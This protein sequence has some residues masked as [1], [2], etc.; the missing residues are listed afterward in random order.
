MKAMAIERYGKKVPLKEME[1]PVPKLGADEVLVEIYAA[2]INPVDYKL[3]DGAL[4]VLRSYKMP[5]I[6]GGDFAGVVKQVGINVT[7]FNVGD[8]VYG[9]VENDNYGTFAEYAVIGEDNA[10]L[11]PDSLSF[12]EAAAIP[13]AGLTAYQALTEKMHVQPGDHVLIHAGAGGVGSY[14]VQLGKALGVHV[15]TTVSSKGEALAKEL[16]ADELI[17]YKEVDFSEPAGRFDSVFDT[18]GGDTTKQSFKAVKDGGHVVSIAAV[19]NARFAVENNLGYL[20]QGL[21]KVVAAKYEK[22]AKEHKAHYSYMFMHPSGEQL[23]YF[24]ELIAE[25]KLRPIIDRV[26][27]FSESQKALDYVE[28]GS[29]KGKVVIQ[30]KE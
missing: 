28:N 16:G 14:A 1:L 18:V 29:T 6:L 27:S 5:L 8:A 20:R 24:N 12:V 23:E 13:L 25:D 21:F 7:K 17:N 26:F 15:T 22:A 10:A 30:M 3:R 19:P 2:S 11:K 9:R 4:R